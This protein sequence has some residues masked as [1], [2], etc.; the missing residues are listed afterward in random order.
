MWCYLLLPMK[1]ALEYF[2]KIYL[3]KMLLITTS[4]CTD[5]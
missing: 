3:R 4:K 1:L 5:N 2:L